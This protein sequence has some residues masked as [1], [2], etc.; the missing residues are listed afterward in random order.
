[1][2][3]H[4]ANHHLIM[5]TTHTEVRLK[6]SLRTEESNR[7]RYKKKV[8]KLRIPRPLVTCNLQELKQNPP[9][10]LTEG[11]LNLTIITVLASFA[12]VAELRNS[13]V[14]LLLMKKLL[15]R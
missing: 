8:H 1:M 4:V 10:H 12:L 6:N 14:A 11:A 9:I 7:D 13:P 15:V 3:I 5:H 2:H